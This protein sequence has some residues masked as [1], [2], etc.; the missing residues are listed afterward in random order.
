MSCD[1]TNLSLSNV[2]IAVCLAVSK[3]GVHEV[4]LGQEKPAVVSSEKELVASLVPRLSNQALIVS[5]KSGG[6]RLSYC[7]QRPG[8][9]LEVEV[10]YV[11]VVIVH[12]AE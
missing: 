9:R 11:F 10:T 4:P 5:D 1:H 7:K 8:T 3:V 12:L 2:F 6:V